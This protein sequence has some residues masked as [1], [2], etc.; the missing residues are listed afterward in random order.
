MTSTAAYKKKIA[1]MIPKYGIAG[2][3]ERYAATLTELLA[4]NPAYELHVIANR[5]GAPSTSVTF[6]RVPVL[7]FPRFLATISFAWFAHR[8][9]ARIG[10]DLIHT[11]DRVFHADLF[12]MHGVPHSFWIREIRQKKMSLFDRVTAWV[13][14]RLV[15]DPRCRFLLPVSTLASDRYCRAFPQIR[16]R[17]QVLSP[18]V[19]LERF[20]PRDRQIHRDRIRR[21]FDLNDSD[22][23]L[24]FVG[25]NFKLK[26]LDTLILALAHAQ[27]HLPEQMVRLLV[28]GKGDRASFQALA[29]EQGIGD[30]LRFAGIC[31]GGME[32]Y[33]GA[34]DVFAL[35]SD[36]DT[37]GMTVLEAMASGLPVLVSTG[38]GAKDL[39]T[40]NRQG[41]IV[42]KSDIQAVAE[43]IV[44]LQDH[45]RRSAM[46]RAARQTAEEQGWD[47]VAKKIS[48]IY[49]EILDNQ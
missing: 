4:K 37:F 42:E 36:F 2:G 12:T 38:V 39:V 7:R 5:W 24:L 32:A 17:L 25:M 16:E 44:C 20:N 30:S 22:L 11:H 8:K 21:Q 3:A 9:A 48:R 27:R 34:A 6:H 49:D 13:E 23:V 46:G 19:D 1:V 18:G 28:V 40:D 47:R 26:G 31:H 41:Y 33:Y 29:A 15:N 35:L 43:R 10:C 14:A 45:Q